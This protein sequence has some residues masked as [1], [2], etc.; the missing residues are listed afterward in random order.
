[1]P[2]VDL[3]R[4]IPGVEV[5]ATFDKCCGMAEI[6]G[7]KKERY[8]LSQKIGDPLIDQIR[9]KKLDLILSDCASCQ[10]KIKNDA[11]VDSIHPITMI[12][13]AMQ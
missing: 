2:F 5:T 3:L 4:L 10:M 7:F 11:K 12:K 13:Q 6:M 9:D 8:E 1:M